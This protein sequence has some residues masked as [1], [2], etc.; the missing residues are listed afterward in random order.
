MKPLRSTLNCL[1]ECS[2]HEYQV[3]ANGQIE[4]FIGWWLLKIFDSLIRIS[5]W[6]MTNDAEKY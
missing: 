1:L 3:V 5:Q 6:R 2:K 4:P